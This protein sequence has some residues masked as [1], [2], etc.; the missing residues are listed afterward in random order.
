MP[1]NERIERRPRR[2]PVPRANS[3]GEYL[4]LMVKPSERT[5]SGSG[6]PRTPLSNVNPLTVSGE[7]DRMPEI[8]EEGCALGLPVPLTADSYPETRMPVRFRDGDG[9]Q[10]APGQRRA[11]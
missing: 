10:P 1:T 9:A 2:T 5:P 11:R 7:P 6:V 3:W 4:D 8:D